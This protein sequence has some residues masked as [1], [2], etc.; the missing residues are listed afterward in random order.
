V[1]VLRSI[2]GYSIKETASLMGIKEGTV[3][4]KLS[5][6]LKKLKVELEKLGYTNG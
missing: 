4:S 6:A 1:I 5:R 2:E 3:M